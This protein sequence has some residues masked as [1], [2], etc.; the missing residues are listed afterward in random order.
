MALTMNDLPTHK[1]MVKNI[2]YIYHTTSPDDTSEGI[3]WYGKAYAECERIA[4]ESGFTPDQVASLMAI[5]SPGMVWDENETA[6]ERI[7]NLYLEGKP[8]AEWVGFSTYPANLLKAER[9]LQGDFTALGGRK[10]KSFHANIMGDVEAVTV[11]RWAVRVALDDPQVTGDKIVPSGDKVYNAI[12]DAY[13]EVAKLVGLYPPDVQ[14]ITWCSFRNQ[15][16]G[17]VKKAKQEVVSDKVLS[18]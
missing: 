1:D 18:V 17:R 7:V 11:D 8:A 16:N 2:L 10:V 6:P 13:R 5:V 9:I 12:A 4:S 14:A 15:Y 3:E